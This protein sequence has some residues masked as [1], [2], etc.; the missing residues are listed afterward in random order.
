MRNQG[1]FLQHDDGLDIEERNER[2]TIIESLSSQWNH[3]GKKNFLIMKI[4]LVI[5]GLTL[6]LLNSSH[7]F[8][9]KTGDISCFQDVVQ[10]WTLPITKYLKSHQN[11]RNSI[12]ILSSVLL[13]ISMTSL[14]VIF[15]FYGESLRLFYTVFPFY[16]VRGL[17]QRI[18]ALKFPAYFIFEDPGFFSISVP[19]FKTNDFFFS[20]H[21][22]IC[23]IFFLEFRRRNFRVLQY[24]SSVAV[25]LNFFVL[26][27]TRGHFIIDLTCGMVYAHYIYHLGVWIEGNTKKSSNPC[28]ELLRARENEASESDDDDDE[29]ENN[30]DAPKSPK[31]Y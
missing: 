4:I 6:L 25:L 12:I 16:V 19:Y 8:I 26:L 30:Y 3:P 17:T 2:K 10:D 9:H 22:G 18:F 13:D 21:V 5:I 14:Y 31:Y 27:V 1:R 20:G 11:S 7:N 15:L 24:T 28:V 23:T 29:E